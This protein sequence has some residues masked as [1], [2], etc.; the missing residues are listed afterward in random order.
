[1]SREGGGGGCRRCHFHSSCK[2]GSRG[3]KGSS[4][5]GDETDADDGACY[6]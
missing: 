2:G 4:A 3:Q 6:R 5:D 1:M